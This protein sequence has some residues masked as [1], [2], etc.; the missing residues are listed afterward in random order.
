M[1]YIWMYLFT[2]AS[3]YLLQLYTIFQHWHTNYELI[4]IVIEF[5]IKLCKP[6]YL[7]SICNIFDIKA[8][9]Q[10]SYVPTSHKKIQGGSQT[11]ANLTRSLLFAVFVS[12]VRQLWRPHVIN[13]SKMCVEL[14][15]VKTSKLWYLRRT[16]GE[17]NLI[18]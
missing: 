6:T 8:C 10:L 16:C 5:N 1:Q 3:L 7:R 18:K 9:Q 4:S 14:L 2:A 12:A 13:L 11:G 17:R 15:D